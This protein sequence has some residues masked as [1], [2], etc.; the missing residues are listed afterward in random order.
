MEPGDIQEDALIQVGLKARTRPAL[1]SRLEPASLALSGLDAVPLLSPTAAH[2]L[3]SGHAVES[4]RLSEF[5]DQKD[6]ESKN[7][8]HISMDRERR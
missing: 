1:Q 3:Q 4:Q 8:G 7:L 6:D 2:R 5:S